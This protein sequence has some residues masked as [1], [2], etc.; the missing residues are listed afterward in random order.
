MHAEQHPGQREAL[1]DHVVSCKA[2]SFDGCNRIARQLAAAEQSA[3]GAVQA[4]LQTS[5]PAVGPGMLAKQQRAA[6]LEHAPDLIERL[7][8]FGNGAKRVG[9]HHG[10]GHGVLQ[11][12]LLADALPQLGREG[13]LVELLLSQLDHRLIGLDAD[14]K[15]DTPRIV[16]GQIQAGAETDLDDDSPGARHDPPAHR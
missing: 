6:R 11:R 5:P 2:G 1:D 13:H 16:V 3:P 9:Y 10:V 4:A 7:G 14:Q 12:Q 8:R 15:V